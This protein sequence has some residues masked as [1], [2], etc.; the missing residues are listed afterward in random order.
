M[1][2][3]SCFPM[4]QVN[5]SLLKLLSFLLLLLLLGWFVSLIGPSPIKH[6]HCGYSLEI[7]NYV[8]F[9]FGLAP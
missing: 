7:D 9:P 1:G 6:L 8:D 3:H 2:L 5:S 4:L